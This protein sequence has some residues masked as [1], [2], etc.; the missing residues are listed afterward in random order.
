MD[1]D[2]LLDRLL[3]VPDDDGMRRRIVRKFVGDSSVHQQRVDRE[4]VLKEI[5]DSLREHFY[6]IE[7]RDRIRKLVQEREIRRNPFSS[8]HHENRGELLKFKGIGKDGKRK[9]G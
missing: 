4:S 3:I 6:Q 5:F 8:Q 2:K 7:M 1:R 9:R